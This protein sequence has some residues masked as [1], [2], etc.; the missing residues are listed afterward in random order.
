MNFSGTFFI[1]FADI[2][3]YC[4]RPCSLAYVVSLSNI[5]SEAFPGSTSIFRSSKQPDSTCL[6]SIRVFARRSR[7]CHVNNCLKTSF[8]PSTEIISTVYSLAACEE[9]KYSLHQ[10]TVCDNITYLFLFKDFV[11]QSHYFGSY[12]KSV[13]SRLFFNSQCLANETHGLNSTAFYINRLSL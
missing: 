10:L 9:G 6:R 4:Y 8:S 1:D 2:N 3:V 11:F 12:Q 5:Q 13:N 7:F